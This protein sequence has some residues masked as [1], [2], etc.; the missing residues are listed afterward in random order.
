MTVYMEC[1]RHAPPQI[2]VVARTD[3]RG[4]PAGNPVASAAERPEHTVGQKPGAS[5]GKKLRNRTAHACTM[6]DGVID[7]VASLFGVDGREIRAAGRSRKP[8][9]RVRQ[10]GMYIAHTSLDL[11]M[12]QVGDG[13]GRDRSTV[14]HACHTIE[15]LREDDDFDVIVTRAE[16]TIQA[17]FRIGKCFA[18]RERVR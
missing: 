2:D 3:A 9:A 18:E 11:T 15:D 16:Q 1:Q 4:E 6:C 17:A 14:M 10:I 12:Q 7:L 5:D 8:V 13:F